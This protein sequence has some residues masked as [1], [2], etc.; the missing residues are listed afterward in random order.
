MLSH[1]YFC[2][3][4]NWRNAQ[5]AEKACVTPHLQ[6][7]TLVELS[8][9]LVVI[10]LIISSVLVGQEI[11]RTAE[12][13]NTI[14]QYTNFN[15]AVVTFRNRY[16]GL[17]GDVTNDFGWT[18]GNAS[19]DADADNDLLAASTLL[20]G[21]NVFFWHQLG[22]SNAA[23]ISGQYS[24]ATAGPTATTLLSFVPLSR[25]GGAWGVF[26][27]SGTNYY[28]LGVTGGGSAGDYST[29]GSLS[30]IDARNIDEKVDDARPGRGL[31]QARGASATDANNTPPTIAAGAGLQCVDVVGATGTY[32]SSIPGYNCTLRFRMVF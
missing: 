8:I 2:K 1:Y 19:G 4:N 15:A 31:V 9:V 24:G 6:G 17:A 14:T 13:R 30:P 7:F 26:S 29:T 5:H 27:D 11:I 20:S 32:A 3:K 10:G 12:L 18:N 23:L 21:E 16:G 25:A 22:S 28:I